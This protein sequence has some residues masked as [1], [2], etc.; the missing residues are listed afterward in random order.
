MRKPGTLEL[1]HVVHP[2]RKQASGL[3]VAVSSLCTSLGLQGHRVE[4]HVVEPAA[5]SEVPAV[6]LCVH[7]GLGSRI[8]LSGSLFQALREHA[9][10]VDV[11]HV[12]GLWSAAHICASRVAG[13]GGPPLIASPHGMLS[14]WA[15]EHHW[16][17]KRVFWWAFQRSALK[18]VTCLHA[19]A[20]SEM[21]DIRRLGFRQPVAVV[22]NGIDLP[23][24]AP[25]REE[26]ARRRLL[27]IGRLHPAKGLERALEAWGRVSSRFPDW[28][29]VMAGPEDQLGYTAVLRQ[30]AGSFGCQRI[31]FL[32]AA[33]G[34]RK[35]ELLGSCD[36][37][38]L[39]SHTENFGIV[40]AEALAS[41]VP[42]V[43]SHNTPWSRLRDERCGWWIGNDAETIA[44]CLLEALRLP[45]GELRLMGRRGRD[46]M[47]R[48]YGS[49]RVAEQ[50]TA[51]YSW[52]KGDS[53]RPSV[54]HLA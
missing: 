9:P 23:E 26:R 42:V 18:R 32:E 13:P 36:L 6:E 24:A 25:M 52:L 45:S 49:T 7:R 1:L 2:F 12:H 40:V 34:R 35:A 51:V 44:T 3:T 38:I 43:A 30:A 53:L 21:E 28:E 48:E 14:E 46:W 11:L 10:R 47:I 50:M 15:F 5:S 37:L 31:H 27:F 39:P 33:Y 19:T 54:V 29:F 20:D 22:A 17:R 16:R 8:G 41:G 4:L